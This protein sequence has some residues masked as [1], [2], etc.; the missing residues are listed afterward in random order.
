MKRGI[1]KECRT[2]KGLDSCI[3]KPIKIIGISS[4]KRESW[5]CAREDP[6]SLKLL[7]IALRYA[8]NA[9]AKTELI[10]LRKLKIGACKECYSTCPAQCR[11]SE[12]LNQCDCY[13]F[14]EDIIVTN[15][16]KIY[17]LEQAYDKF[18]KKEF[19]K[20]YNNENNFAPQDDMWKVYKAMREA[21]GIIFSTFTSFY[22]RPSLL[23][24]M[25][26]RLTALDGGVEE[27]FGDGKN[28]K[29]SVKYAKNPKNK[30][31]QRLFGKWCAFINCSKEGDS[32]TP[33]LL[34]AC[35]MLGMRIIPLSVAYNVRWYG[36]DPTHRSDLKNT[37]KDRYTM[38]LVEH[39][40]RQIVKEIKS[41]HK[42]R[43][44]GTYTNAV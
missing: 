34:K 24:N 37:L 7:K 41:N 26:S 3:G 40:G 5:S 18:S 23:Q 9:G 33:D 42:L 29:N 6:I 30:Y 21:D 14:K 27:L 38:G 17:N 1:V 43:V 16:E 28:L 10:D 44:Y 4:G 32:V 8:E 12:Q 11:F 2:I 36:E 25:F 19:F 15:D 35:T 39:I 31:K 20:L 13:L 22:S